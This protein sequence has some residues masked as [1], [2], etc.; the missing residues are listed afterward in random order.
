MKIQEELQTI[1]LP[2][3]YKRN[4]TDCFLDPY[5]EKLIP[6][7]PEEYVRQRVAAWLEKKLSVPNRVIIVEQ[8]L[9]HYGIQRKGRADIV[10]HKDTDE[11]ML[12]IAVVECKAN[13]V[14]ISDT[15]IQQV[16]RYADA[17]ECEYMLLSNGIDIFCYKY[18]EIQELYFELSDIPTYS[19]MVSGKANYM[20]VKQPILRPTLVQMHERLIQQK[21]I[22]E[23]IIGSATEKRIVPHIVNL[24]ECFMDTTHHLPVKETQLFKLKED[25]GVRLMNYSNAAGYNYFAPYRSFLICDYNENHQFVSIG[26]NAYG[27]DKTILCVAIDDYKKSHHSLQLLI[28]TYMYI[29]GPTATFWHSGRIAVG[30]QGSGKSSELKRFLMEKDKS[31]LLNEK[32]LLGR[33]PLNKILYLDD[34]EMSD[35]VYHLIKY[36]LLRD[37]Y[38]NNIKLNKHN[39][40]S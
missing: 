30:H 2:K 3:I 11:G 9:S 37:E 21:Y 1:P 40:S 28:D 7:T 17:M 26:F 38:R 8:H 24:F 29:Q 27:N 36:A 32:I 10:I 13:N 6:A 39:L 19:D 16:I 14:F 18:D 31:L 15:I 33:I 4:G 34:I 5:R 25:Y 20:P 35:F 12:P 22:D 23:W